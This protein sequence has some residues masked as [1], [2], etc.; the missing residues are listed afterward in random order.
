[1]WGHKGIHKFMHN[2]GKGGRG[3]DGVMWKCTNVLTHRH[4]LCMEQDQIRDNWDMDKVPHR[5]THL[6]AN[7]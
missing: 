4:I 6:H 3:E 2:Y 5:G 1:M 7:M